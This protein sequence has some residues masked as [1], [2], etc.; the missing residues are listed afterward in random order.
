MSWFDGKVREL[1]RSVLNSAI[2][3]YLVLEKSLT[4]LNFIW[5]KKGAGA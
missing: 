1:Q 4:L 3:S 5:G 2:H